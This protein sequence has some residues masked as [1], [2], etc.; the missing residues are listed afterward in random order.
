MNY[1]SKLG[2]LLAMASL[3]IAVVWGSAQSAAPQATPKATAEQQKQLDRLNQL[4]EQLRKDRGSLH[5]AI[6]QYGWD[7][8]QVDAAHESLFRDREEY[9]KLRRSL[10]A[11]GVAVPPASGF[12]PDMG[13][14]GRG[15][16]LG[17]RRGGGPH[18]DCP[19]MPDCPCA[20]R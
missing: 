6:T 8:E 10:R 1:I 9:R 18:Y 4:D 2:L 13:A 19:Y 20:R 14:P 17:Q 16:R 12:G 15:G 11:A 5:Q 7:S 3:G